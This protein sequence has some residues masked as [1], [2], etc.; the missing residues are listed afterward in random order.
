MS[1]SWPSAL[2]SSSSSR[3]SNTSP[4]ETLDETSSSSLAMVQGEVKD[5]S[6]KVQELQNAYE[7]YLDA[8]QVGND[9][10]FLINNRMFQM[11]STLSMI[12]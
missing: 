1:S 11:L 7:E 12:K 8:E 3:S 10:A 5:L 2:V 9:D 6:S 4:V